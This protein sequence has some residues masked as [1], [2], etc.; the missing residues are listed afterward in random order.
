M[1]KTN[2]IELAQEPISICPELAV[3]LCSGFSDT[4][5]EE[6]VWVPGICEYIQKSINSYI[7]ANTIKRVAA[8]N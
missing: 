4:V 2:A 3:V 6:N 5:N 8:N 1:P 7:L